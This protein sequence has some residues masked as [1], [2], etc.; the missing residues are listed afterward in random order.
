MT[1]P[2]IE[3]D[4]PNSS[5]NVSVFSGVASVPASSPTAASRVCIVGVIR[6]GHS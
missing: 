3:A 4:S 1:A 2:I 5:T 6:T